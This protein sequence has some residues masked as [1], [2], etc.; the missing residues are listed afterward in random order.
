MEEEQNDLEQPKRTKKERTPAQVEAF[1]KAQE[2]RKQNDM[3]TITLNETKN[4][5]KKNENDAKKTKLIEI[6]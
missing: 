6:R 3:N 4:E 2:I 1:K 5:L